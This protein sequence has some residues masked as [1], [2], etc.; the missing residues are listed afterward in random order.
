MLTLFSQLVNFSDVKLSNLDTKEFKAKN[1]NEAL[2]V[3]KRQ[4][5]IDE[6]EKKPELKNDK[7]AHLLAADGGHRDHHNENKFGKAIGLSLTLGF[8]LMFIVDQF[9]KSQTGQFYKYVH[10]VIVFFF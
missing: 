7:L 3:V 2:N 6:I 8:L 9:S 5:S 1:N 10:I 4:I